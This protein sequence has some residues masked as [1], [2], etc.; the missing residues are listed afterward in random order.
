MSSVVEHVGGNVKSLSLNLVGPATIVANASDN[1]ADITSGQADGLAVVQRL[2]SGEK[3]EVLLSQIGQLEHQ[4]ASLAG[5][6]SFPCCVESLAGCGNG[7]IDVLLG[8]FA[9]GGDD[10]LGCGVDDL[11]LLLVDTLNPLVVDEPLKRAKR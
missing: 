10:L 8:T 5:C 1:S 7:K 6:D 11:K 4:A 9:D 2:D 3:I